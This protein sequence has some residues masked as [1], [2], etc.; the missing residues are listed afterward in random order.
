LLQEIGCHL[1]ADAAGAAEEQEL[2]AC[3]VLGHVTLL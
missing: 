1:G 2:A 3:E